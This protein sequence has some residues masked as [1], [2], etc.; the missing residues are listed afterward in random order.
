MHSSDHVAYLF[1][2]LY[3]FFGANGIQILWPST[4]DFSGHLLFLWPSFHSPSLDSCTPI[5]PW[6]ASLSMLFSPCGLGGANPVPHSRRGHLPQGIMFPTSEISSGM[7]LELN[8]SHLKSNGIL[9]TQTLNKQDVKAGTA[10]AIFQLQR[11]REPIWRQNQT[12]HRV[13]N[14]KESGLWDIVWALELCHIW[15]Q[16]WPQN[17]HLYA[18]LH[19]SELG[20][21]FHPLRV[22]GSC[23][24][25]R[26]HLSH[27]SHT[28]D[29]STLRIYSFP[30]QA[31]HLATPV[32]LECS[33]TF[34]TEIIPIL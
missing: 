10:T 18:S 20:W 14:S 16:P 31:S 17:S 25:Q 5:L 2:N 23:L 6:R 32:F 33:P 22:K 30:E 8:W 21:T 9:W 15:S 12:K 1:K 7:G 13:E 29:A 4:P 34:L 19:W 27:P 26:F 28:L 3:W 24:M 11:K